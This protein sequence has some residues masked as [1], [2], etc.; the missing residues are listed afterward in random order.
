MFPDIP[1]DPLY[2]FVSLWGLML[3]FLKSLKITFQTCYWFRS[4]WKFLGFCFFVFFSLRAKSLNEKY[5]N[6]SSRLN[7][8]HGVK[9]ILMKYYEWDLHKCIYVFPID[10]MCV[11]GSYNFQIILFT[12]SMKSIIFAAQFYFIS[13]MSWLEKVF[14][15]HLIHIETNSSRL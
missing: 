14:W 15:S 1:N 6:F 13:Q 4:L 5:Y 2:K 9:Y 3:F 8:Y 7:V 12:P 10:K 11:C